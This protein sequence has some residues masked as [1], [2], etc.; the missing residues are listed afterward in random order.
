MRIDHSILNIIFIP[1]KAVKNTKT[2]KGHRIALITKIVEANKNQGKKAGLLKRKKSP[3]GS[4]KE[5]QGPL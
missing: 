3:N 1:L 2:H 4:L 5:S